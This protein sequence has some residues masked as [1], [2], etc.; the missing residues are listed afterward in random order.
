VQEIQGEW[1]YDAAFVDDRWLLVKTEPKDKKPTNLILVDTEK[2]VGGAPLLSE[3]GVENLSLV[4]SLPSGS[5]TT[6]YC[7]EN[8]EMTD[9]APLVIRVEALLKLHESHEGGMG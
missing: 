6:H 1:D 5:H 4:H 8:G 3:S 7:I 2:F 9:F